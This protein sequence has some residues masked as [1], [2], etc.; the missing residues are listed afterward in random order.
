MISWLPVNALAYVACT[1]IWGS[2]WMAIKFGLDGVPPFYGAG[3]RFVIAAAV[4]WTMILVSGKRKPLS[5]QGK[6][7]AWVAS[8]LGFTWNYALVYWAETRVASGL[9]AVLFSLSPLLTAFFAAALGAERPG[10]R[11]VAGAFVGVAGVV[12]LMWPEKG[13][14]AADPW[15]LL[16]AFLAC[17]GSALNLVLQSRWAKGEDSWRL[18]A[19]AMS[20]GAAL[21]LL[22][23]FVAESGETA[24]WSARNVAALLYLS[25]AGSVAAFLFLYK[26]LRELPPSRVSLMTLLFPV[27]ALFLGWSVLGEVPTSK[28]LLGCVLILAGVG[29]ALLTKGPGTKSTSPR[30]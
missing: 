2:T 6:K 10:L 30:S 23:S 4:L 27:V 28:G 11:H 8:L 1:L 5:E 26:L 20:I 15:G 25:L 22:M 16:A 24:A 7:A 3:M 29:A 18:N 12:L 9:V 17:A 21:L 13:L 19:Q 14:T